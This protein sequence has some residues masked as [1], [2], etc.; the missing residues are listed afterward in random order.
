MMGRSVGRDEV[1]ALV[2]VLAL[3]GGASLRFTQVQSRRGLLTKA[4]QGTRIF[5][6]VAT[7]VSWVGSVLA[8]LLVLAE[9]VLGPLSP[10][11]PVF[12]AL[13]F[14]LVAPPI[15]QMN[16]RLT[17]LD[18]DTERDEDIGGS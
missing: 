4:G 2:G 10:V 12:L 9:L 13:A 1:L 3:L 16:A 18:A 14:A 5:F 15:A 6:S 17:P 7:W 8:W 11:A